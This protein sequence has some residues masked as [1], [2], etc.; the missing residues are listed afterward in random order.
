MDKETARQKY[1]DHFQAGNW[2][3]IPYENNI[4]TVMKVTHIVWESEHVR[5][6]GEAFEY[7]RDDDNAMTSPYAI[8]QLD[9]DYDDADILIKSTPKINNEDIVEQY[10]RVA[11]RCA[12]RKFN[13]RSTF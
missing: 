5:L 3:I 9:F 8:K 2:Y 4:V 10:F 1:A 6:F 7:D 12:L 13:I 11:A